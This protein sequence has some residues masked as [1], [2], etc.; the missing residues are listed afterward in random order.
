MVLGYHGN[1]GEGCRK[2]RRNEEQKGFKQGN[3]K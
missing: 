1:L 3:C 2:T